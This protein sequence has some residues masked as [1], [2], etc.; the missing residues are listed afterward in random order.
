[1]PKLK[2]AKKVGALFLTVAA[3]RVLGYLYDQGVG[4]IVGIP[5]Y[6]WQYAVGL[7]FFIILIVILWPLIS[8]RYD[9][10]RDEDR[11]KIEQLRED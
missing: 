7:V 2:I 1:M 8:G 4:H 5:I 9:K 3:N 11:K 10:D 6:L